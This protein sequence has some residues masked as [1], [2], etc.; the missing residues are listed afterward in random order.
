LY[1]KESTNMFWK[2]KLKY[3]ALVIRGH[4]PEYIKTFDNLT[5]A[6]N[7][8]NDFIEKIDPDH[9]CIELNDTWEGGDGWGNG[10]YI[11]VVEEN[12]HFQ[13]EDKIVQI[14]AR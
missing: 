12:Y 11:T 13:K 14:M 10:L 9:P 1:F 7:C 3:I 8:A 4:T 5:E 6:L 2:K